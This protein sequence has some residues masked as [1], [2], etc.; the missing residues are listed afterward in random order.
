MREILSEP[1]ASALMESTRSIGYTFESAVADIIDNSIAA[2]CQNIWIYSPP[3]KPVVSILDDGFGMDNAKLTEAMRYGTDLGLI[4]SENDMG[5]FGLGLKMASLSQCRRLTVVSKRE[6]TISA[7]RWDLDHIS[8]TRKWSL[9]KLDE[10]ECEDFPQFADLKSQKTGTLILWENLD[11]LYGK[12]TDYR[13]QLVERLNSTS[14]HVGLTFHRFMDAE[15]SIPLKIWINNNPVE[16]ADPFLIYH[17]TEPRTT[18]YDTQEV[19][20]DGNT[21]KL[22]GYLLPP[23]HKMTSEQRKVLGSSED[24]IN[25]QGFYVYRNRRLIIPGRWLRLDRKT[26]LRKHARVKVDIPASADKLWEIDIKKSSAQVPPVFREQFRRILGKVT[27]GSEN[28]ANYRGKK[29]NDKEK[30]KMWVKTNGRDDYWYG[31]NRDHPQV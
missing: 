5:R 22:T 17:H 1:D 14:M 13:E 7:C 16:P 6:G 15:A 12:S 8:K 3:D 26:E 10:S 18:K 4:R 11:K 24:L 20:I 27:D 30:I 2:A 28:L 9:L 23:A 21:V 19:T 25:T 29:E 31:V